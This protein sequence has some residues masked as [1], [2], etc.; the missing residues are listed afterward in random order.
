MVTVAILMRAR[1]QLPTIFKSRQKISRH[2]CDHITTF[3]RFHVSLSK[4]IWPKCC[5]T[6]VL[7]KCVKNLKNPRRDDQILC[8]SNLSTNVYWP[9]GFSTNLKIMIARCSYEVLQ[10]SI[11][12]I[13]I[14]EF[15][16]YQLLLNWCRKFTSYGIVHKT[17]FWGF[18]VSMSKI[19]SLTYIYLRQY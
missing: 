10:T 11:V 3:W 18:H 19:F 1:F 14:S 8:W 17:T 15:F 5:L 4:T 13:S 2:S 12:G 6:E 9:N 7:K 16:S